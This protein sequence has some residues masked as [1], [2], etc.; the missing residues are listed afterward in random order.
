MQV[1]LIYLLVTAAI[2]SDTYDAEIAAAITDVQSIH[3]VPAALVKAI[4]RRESN[5]NPR[6]IST[7]GAIGL[8][9]VMPS[10]AWRVGLAEANLFHPAENILA[11][12]RLLAV[13]LRYYQGDLISALVAYNARPRKPFAPVPRNGETPW[14]VAAVLRFFGEYSARSSPDKT[15]PSGS[16]GASRANPDW[17]LVGGRP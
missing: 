16:E 15:A 2:P 13:L 3:Q 8:M 10:M 12:T 9:Q 14:Y 1:P 4:I 6:A 7:A 17:L 5:F 11:G